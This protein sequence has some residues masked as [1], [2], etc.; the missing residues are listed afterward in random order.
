MAGDYV[1]DDVPFIVLV[2]SNHVSLN[3]ANFCH[4]L[5][6]KLLCLLNSHLQHFAGS[7]LKQAVLKFFG[8]FG[9]GAEPQSY[10]E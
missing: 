1:C 6:R 7:V 2:D 8:P 10:R 4:F 9:Q 5:R 3:E